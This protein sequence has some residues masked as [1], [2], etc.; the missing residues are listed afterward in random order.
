MS[1]DIRFD[2]A[3]CGK[4]LRAAD[5]LAGRK[6]RCTGCRTTVTVPEPVPQFAAFVPSPPPARKPA[7]DDDAPFFSAMTDWTLTRFI[8]LRMIR[9]GYV[10]N[11]ASLALI[12]VLIPAYILYVAAKDERFKNLSGQDFAR[13][14]LVYSVMTLA[15]W[16]VLFFVW[17]WMR[18]WYEMLV[19]FFST[20]SYIRKTEHHCAEL[21]STATQIH[22]SIVNIEHNTNPTP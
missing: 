1:K 10:A 6:V 5:S 11:S 20:H 2:C 7:D 16:L 4:S 3:L 13:F 21:V 14:V 12:A 18:I 8:S 19:V 22:Q 15:I 17:V 9:R